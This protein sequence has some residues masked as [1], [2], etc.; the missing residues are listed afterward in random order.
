MTSVLVEGELSASCPGRFTSRERALGTHWIGGWVGP[1]ARLDDVYKI[2]FLTLPGLELR[3]LCRPSRSHSLFLLRSPGSLCTLICIHI[4]GYIQNHVLYGQFE[5]FSTLKMRLHC[6]LILRLPIGFSWYASYRPRCKRVNPVLTVGLYITQTL[7]QFIR[8]CVSV[9][10]AKG[11][12]VNLGYML[13]VVKYC[14][15][16]RML[17]HV[18]FGDRHGKNTRLCADGRF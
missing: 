5:E 13:S 11:R 18:A 8:T 3:P 2:K 10:G 17:L 9:D 4:T 15:A 1:R 16:A 14:I 12:V 6:K 7:R